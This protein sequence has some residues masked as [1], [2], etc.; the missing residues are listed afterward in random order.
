MVRN[1]EK[2]GTIWEPATVSTVKYSSFQVYSFFLTVA[3]GKVFPKIFLCPVMAV[4]MV[5]KRLRGR[6]GP[7]I[8]P[9]NALFSSASV[10]GRGMGKIR[11]DNHW[12]WTNALSSGAF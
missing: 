12:R 1:T 4:L 7:G 5:K 2:A 8:V 10:A 6:S 3:K 9:A 11:V